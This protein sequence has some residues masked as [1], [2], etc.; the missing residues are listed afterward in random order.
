MDYKLLTALA[1]IIETQS[2]DL[3]AAQLFISQSAISQRIKLLEE[4]IGQPVLIRRQP[5]ELTTV[6]EQLLSHFKKVK[7]LEN[8]LLPELMPDNAVKAMKVSLAVN[9]DSIATWFLKALTPVLQE[10]LIELNLLIEPEDRTLDRLR[11]GEAIGAVS[12]IKNPLKGYRSFE[13]GSMNYCL[14]CSKGFKEKYFKHGV[15]QSSL[16]MAPAISYDHKDAM[17]IRYIVDNFGLE[18]SEYYCHTVRSSEAFVIL[19]KQG[20][21]YCLVP[22]LQIKNELETGELV[23]LC[24]GKEL[25]RTLYW[26][27]WVLVKGVNKK[28]SQ[29]IIQTAKTLLD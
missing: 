15:T 8:E 24:P 5:I 10:N 20:V 6:G 21:A 9:A 4:N 3:A 12:I 14:V 22:Y 27:S 25:N 19:A 13:L 11:S 1:A 7:Q 29:Q 28:I 2:F 16:K 18:A 17:H 23:N 26:H